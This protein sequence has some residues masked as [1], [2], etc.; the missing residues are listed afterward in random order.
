MTLPRTVPAAGERALADEDLQLALYITYELHYRGFDQVST[1]ME[2]HPSVL[3]IRATL[4]SRFVEALQA[5]IPA[6]PDADPSDVIG[7]TL[8][9]PAPSRR[10][11]G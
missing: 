11:R 8:R 7:A 5:T 9:S 1:D 2:W 4:E 10:C 6:S 3:A